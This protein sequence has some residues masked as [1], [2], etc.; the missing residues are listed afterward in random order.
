MKTL[1]LVYVAHVCML[2]GVVEEQTSSQAATLR[3]VI[4][5]LDARYKGF[6]EMF[7]D[8]VTRQLRWDAAIYYSPPGAPPVSVVDL[9][10]PVQD[11]AVITFW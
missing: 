9:D 5:E 1:Q 6:C 8:A 2:S 3:Q 4:D 11:Q 10:Q 7:V